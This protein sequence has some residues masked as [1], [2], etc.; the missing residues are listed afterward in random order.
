[1]SEARETQRRETE[2]RVLEAAGELF[3]T[4]G[5][6]VTTVRDIAA[7]AGVSTGTVMSVGDKNA[8]LVACF[9]R[10]IDEIHRR[11]TEDS[12]ADSAGV[13]EQ[14]TAL[15][16]PFVELFTSDPELSR[17]YGSVLVS[18]HTESSIFT[19]LASVLIS[20]IETVVHSAGMPNAHAL[21]ESIYFAY[22]GRLFTWSAKND[23]DPE[24]LKQS[25]NRIV[26]SICQ[27]QGPLK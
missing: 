6:A 3:Q 5:F 21:A 22:I 18:G 10:R 25:L 1:M 17:T 16:G 19:E 20:E 13:A 8:L 23:H 26:A 14:I 4:K 7:S 24:Q 12:L 2:S 9:D 11:R 27:T 15:V